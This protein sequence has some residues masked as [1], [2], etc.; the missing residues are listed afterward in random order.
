MQ[1][2]TSIARATESPLGVHP[3]FDK[4]KETLSQQ[5]LNIIESKLSVKLTLERGCF[6][7]VTRTSAGNLSF[8]AFSPTVTEL[9]D[10][11]KRWGFWRGRRQGNRRE[12]GKLGL[13]LDESF[14]E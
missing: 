5:K 2:H 7:S 14:F 12:E 10:T 8:S 3:Q 6:V 4:I 13:K 9:A 11:A 1:L